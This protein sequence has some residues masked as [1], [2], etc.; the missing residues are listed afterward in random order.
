MGYIDS[1]STYT[2]DQIVDRAAEIAKERMTLEDH[3]FG[4]ANEVRA[5]RGQAAV[6]VGCPDYAIGKNGI[7]T[8]VKDALSNIVHFCRR[9]G[10]D[11]QSVFD[12]A[13]FAAE[14]DLED[15]DEAE[16]D[17]VNFPEEDH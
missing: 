4:I 7:D 1:L 11:V 8:D 13:L 9:A 10:I 14:G 6:M 15:G 16:R 2:R 12:R 17:A 3:E 5:N